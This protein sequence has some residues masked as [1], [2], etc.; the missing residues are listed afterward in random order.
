MSA[1]VFESTGEEI[2]GTRVADPRLSTTF[3]AS[4]RQR[5]AGL[6]L[7]MTDDGPVRRAAGEVICGT[8]IDLGRLR[9]DCSFLHWRLEGREGIGRYDILR[10]APAQPDAA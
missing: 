10:K 6:E 3:D 8:T 9:L 5:R 1:V 7:W 4:G 2:H